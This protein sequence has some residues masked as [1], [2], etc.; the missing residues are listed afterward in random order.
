[1]A[2]RSPVSQAGSGSALL[3]DTIARFRFAKDT[4]APGPWLYNCK[5]WPCGLPATGPPA[6][7][8]VACPKGN[9]AAVG[10]ARLVLSNRTSIAP[11]AAYKLAS[12]SRSCPKSPRTLSE[13]L[14]IVPLKPPG[15]TKRSKLPGPPTSTPN[16]GMSGRRSQLHSQ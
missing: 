3:R 12:N 1:M 9:C 8:N 5:Y 16:A 2:S 7:I 15:S 11:F 10:N 6:A 14:A 4:S 13:G